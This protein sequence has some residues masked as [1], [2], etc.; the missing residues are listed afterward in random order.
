MNEDHTYQRVVYSS[1]E[2]SDQDERVDEEHFHV[3]DELH[4]DS[5]DNGIRVC[6]AYP[7]CPYSPPPGDEDCPGCRANEQYCDEDP[8]LTLSRYLSFPA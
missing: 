4:P 3:L 8:G 7:E 5:K 6:R 1:R 2:S